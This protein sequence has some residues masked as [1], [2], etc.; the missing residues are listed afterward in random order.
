V[1]FIFADPAMRSFALNFVPISALTFFVYWFYH[2][3]SRK[4]VSG[5]G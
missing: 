2:P 5:S 4:P 3:W 1:R